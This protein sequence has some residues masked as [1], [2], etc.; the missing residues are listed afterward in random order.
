MSL[1]ECASTAL[2]P[3]CTLSTLGRAALMLGALALAPAACGSGA[4]G[5]GSIACEDVTDCPL[6]LVC[7]TDQGVCVDPD[8]TDPYNCDPPLPGCACE[9]NA[10]PITCLTGEIHPDLVATCRQGRSIC[11]DN[12][13][14]ACEVVPNEYCSQVGVSSGDFE[15][16]DENSDQVELGPEGELVLDPEVKDISFGF[17]WIANTGENTVSKIDIDTGREVA[18][19]ASVRGSGALGIPG[20][21][22]PGGYDGDAGN[23]GNC[24]SRTAVD[25]KG[26]AFVA[27]RAFGEQ[28]T[29][30]KFANSSEECVDHNG[31]G[32]ID[33]SF[34]VDADGMINVQDP[35]EF[36]GEADE[37]ILWTVPVGGGNGV[38]RG[39]AIDA[40]GPDGEAGN[41]WVGLYNEQRVVQLSGDTGAPITNGGSPVSVSVGGLHPYGCAVDGGGVLWVTGLQDGDETFLAKV[42][43]F[44]AT[45]MELYAIPDDDDGCTMGYGIAIDTDQRIWLG[46]WQCRDVKAFDQVSETWYRRD[47]DDVSNTRGVAP[48]TAGNVWVAFTDGQVGRLKVADIIAM[49]Q[50][51]PVTVFDVPEVVGPLMGPVSSTIGVGIDRNGACWAVSRNDDAPVGIATRI[52]ASD[53]LESFPVG[54]NPYTYSDF[55]GFGLGTVVRPDGYWRGII[56]G[57]ATT[58]AVSEWTELMWY[59]NEPPGTHVRMRVRV[60]DTIAG[61]D[62]AVW[63]GPWDVPP[64]DLAAAGVP[65][66]RYMQVEVQLSTEDPDVTPSF[67]G[68][69]VSFTCPGIAPVP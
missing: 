53:N 69:T 45:L 61:I 1:V 37:C 27:N 6:E 38:P 32:I 56:E 34:D 18:R 10:P 12:V 26:D 15:P 22:T 5:G 54:R 30:T 17:L 55:T 66:A 58:D 48:D 2:H 19:Y 62:A 23:C 60:A 29:V 4:K 63:Y 68:F 52:D 67:I 47:F 46:G 39:L 16:D 51:A 44:S 3:G 59:E 8:G 40:G 50:N 57:C 41:V 42:N 14:Q 9:T 25:F 20:V 11:I 49:G 13:Y 21:P 33:T 31:N 28:G 65:P 43:T 24:P 35:G 64:V 36:L 7:D